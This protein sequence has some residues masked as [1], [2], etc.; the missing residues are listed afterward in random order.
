MADQRQQENGVNYLSH[1]PKAVVERILL[2]VNNESLFMCRRVNSQFYDII[3]SESFW[4]R[5]CCQ[6]IHCKI[7]YD[8]TQNAWYMSEKF[9]G[10]F[11]RMD[12][13]RKIV[14]FKHP[15]LLYKNYHRL[16][17]HHPFIIVEQYEELSVTRE[18]IA[19][20]NSDFKTGFELNLPVLYKILTRNYGLQADY[21]PDGYVAINLKYVSP[22]KIDLSDIPRE[23]RPDFSEKTTISF[24]IF[25]TGS[26]ILNSAKS[27]EQQVDAYNFLNKIFKTHYDKIWHANRQKR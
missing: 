23:D 24:F 9:N 14:Y 26:V 2:H 6:D 21:S 8:Q 10:R 27:I 12:T 19:L 4:E 1:L 15:M 3:R 20:I 22:F 16:D 5:K 17:R 18:L 25:S 13:I 11:R 7:M